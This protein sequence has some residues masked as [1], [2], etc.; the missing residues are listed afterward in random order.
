MFIIV[1]LI[2][3]TLQNRVTDWINHQIDSHSP[4]VMQKIGIY[5]LSI[6]DSPFGLTGLVFSFV[7]LG[8]IVHAYFDTRRT[9]APEEGT[10]EPLATPAPELLSPIRIEFDGTAFVHDDPPTPPSVGATFLGSPLGLGLGNTQTRRRTYQIIL[11]NTSA[12]MT[13]PNVRV[14]MESIK[15]VAALPDRYVKPFATEYGLLLKFKDSDATSMTFSPDMRSAMEVVSHS[16]NILEN[17]KIVIC[18]SGT[19]FNHNGNLH[20]MTIKVT[21]EGIKS[22]SEK[23]EVWVNA[24]GELMMQNMRGAIARALQDHR[25]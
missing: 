22:M 12:T 17:A 15:E 7:I 8:L 13:I 10:P 20:Q 21:G 11:H 18:R 9:V 2:S 14:E 1:W 6:I 25:L 4:T 3:Q 24:S 19:G 16:N 5:L 23:F